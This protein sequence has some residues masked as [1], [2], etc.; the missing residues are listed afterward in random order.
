MTPIRVLLADDHTLVR[1]GLRSLLQD[2]PEVEV[3]GEAGD[4]AEAVRLVGATN[5]DIVLMDIAMPTL[6]GLAATERIAAEFPGTRVIILSMNAT[7][8]YVFQ[9]LRVGARGYLLKDSDPPELGLALRAVMRGDTYLSPPISKHVVADY[10]RRTGG[11]ESPL[12]RLTPRQREVLRLIARG[13]STKEIARELG[14]S[15]KTVATHRA[16]LMEQL[17]IHDVAGLVRYAM[18]AGLVEPE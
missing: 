11:A 1:K 3:V 12:D 10:V 14:I 13:R 5:P 8:E 6:N 15:G 7:E 9:A 16:Q 18:R 2:L 4:G 17:G